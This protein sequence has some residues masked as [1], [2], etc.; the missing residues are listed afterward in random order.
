MKLNEE[1]LFEFYMSMLVQK[2]AAKSIPTTMW[3][4]QTQ[5]SLQDL[6]FL[7]IS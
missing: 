4:L 7:D 1:A 5:G 3:G 2:F 6:I